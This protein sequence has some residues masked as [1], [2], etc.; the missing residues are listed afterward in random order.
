MLDARSRRRGWRA[1]YASNTERRFAPSGSSQS[2]AGRPTRSFS[3][4]KNNTRTR[5]VG[6]TVRITDGSRPSGVAPGY[7]AGSRNDTRRRIAHPRPLRRDR[8]DGRGLLRQLSGLDGGGPGGPVPRLRL[9][10]SRHGARGRHPA[11]GGG[12]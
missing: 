10:I 12:G 9:R 4:P 5:I 11:G 3:M 8:P 2:S 7:N 1:A 6:G